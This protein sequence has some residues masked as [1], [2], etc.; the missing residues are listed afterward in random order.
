MEALCARGAGRAAH[1]LPGGARLLLRRLLPDDRRPAAWG[2]AACR[3]ARVRAAIRR[4]ARSVRVAPPV[5]RSVERAW[6]CQPGSVRAA[7]RVHGRARRHRPRPTGRRSQGPDRPHRVRDAVGKD[8][9]NDRDRPPRDRRGEDAARAVDA[10]PTAHHRARVV[11]AGETPGRPAQEHP[12][13]HGAR[14]PGDRRPAVLRPRRRRS[15]RDCVGGLGLRDRPQGV[16]A[17]REHADAAAHQEHVPD[18]GTESDPQDA[19]SVHGAHPRAPVEQGSG[20]RAL[21]ERR[22]ARPARL[23]CRARGGRSVALVLRQ[24]HHERVAERGGPHRR[25]HPVAATAF[26]VCPSRPR[27]GTPRCGVAGD[28]GCRVRQRRSRRPCVEGTS[29]GRRPCARV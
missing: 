8:Q 10:R 18:P 3:P 4:P 13:A 6:L 28:G 17:R 29:A 12:A 5:D 11:G 14:R 15:H 27:Q 26:A 20:A 1:G 7:R 25:R 9:G 24:G 21:S 23:V 19:G 22:L 2:H 16:P